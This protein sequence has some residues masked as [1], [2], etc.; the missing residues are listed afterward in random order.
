MQDPTSRRKFLTSLGMLAAGSL[1]P[2][3]AFSFK[4]KNKKLK[5]AL[6]GVG[7]R[8]TSFWGKR[9]VEQYPGLLEFVGLSDINPGRLQYAL[10]YRGVACPTFIDSDEM[11]AKT[12]PDLLIVATTN[13]THHEFI[14]KGLDFGCDVLTEKPLTTDEHKCQAI[15]DTEKHTLTLA[16]MP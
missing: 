12:R 4:I 10:S 7:I 15:L 6:V 1:F 9:L 11:L 14:I 8:G 5:V 2:A 13:S 16:P 3:S